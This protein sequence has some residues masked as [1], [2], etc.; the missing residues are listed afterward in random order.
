MWGCRQS[1]ASSKESERCEALSARWYNCRS[2]TDL[3]D[4]SQ[5]V[6][7][8]WPVLQSKRGIQTENS[9]EIDELRSVREGLRLAQAAPAGRICLALQPRAQR[10]KGV[11]GRQRS[12]CA[13]T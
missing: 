8:N 12:S 10:S 13:G 1:R 7:I 9:Q 2:W 6:L 11:S 5:V 3:N 4:G